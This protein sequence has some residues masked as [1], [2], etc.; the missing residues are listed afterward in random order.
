MDEK[1][2]GQKLQEAR[3][4]VGLTQ[5]EMCQRA[6]LSY[7]TLAKIERGAIKSPSIFTVQAIADVVGLP[8]DELLQ[9]QK[10]IQSSDDKKQSK[11]GIRFVYFD[12]NGVMVRF[13]H[14]AFTTIAA[15][16]GASADMIETA[17]WHY[18][19]E[20]C[21]G[22]ITVDQFNEHMAQQ[23]GLEH[24]DWRPYYFESIDAIAE[25][26][27]LANWAVQHYRV[28]LMSNIM[29][30]FLDELRQRWLVPPIQYDS[31][32]D[33]SV[34]KAVKPEIAIYEAAQAQAGVAPREILLIDDSRANLMAAEKLGWHVMWFDDFRPSES[35]ERVRAALEF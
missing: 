23:L 19:D 24:F 8:L 31:I 27:E 29:P 20:A 6:G 35:T 16:T 17:F 7:S 14:R 9:R 32:I 26:H 10:P 4:H 28:G 5:Q 1:A 12:V 11:S 18:N 30:G 13:F 3:Q 33:S 22:D 25:M 21:R 2:L 15:N 34:V